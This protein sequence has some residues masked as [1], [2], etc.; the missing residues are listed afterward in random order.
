MQLYVHNIML[1][2]KISVNFSSAVI[3][4]NSWNALQYHNV[5]KFYETL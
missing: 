3:A 2:R 1:K 5:E 4:G